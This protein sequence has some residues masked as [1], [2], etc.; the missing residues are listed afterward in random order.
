MRIKKETIEKYRKQ[1]DQLIEQN[2]FKEALEISSKY[3]LG[4]NYHKGYVICKTRLMDQFHIQEKELDTLNFIEK[5][6]PHYSSQ[7]MYLY[8]EDEVRMKFNIKS[9]V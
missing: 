1:V 3:P 4:Y 9:R 7:S 2:R 6:N 5:K 8:L